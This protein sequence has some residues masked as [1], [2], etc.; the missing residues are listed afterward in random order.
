MPNEW[1]YSKK[2]KDKRWIKY[3][4]LVL[5]RDDHTCQDCGGKEEW[6]Y[7][8]HVHHIKY[9]SNKEPWEY[10]PSYVI[11]LCKRC[12]ENIHGLPNE[13]DPYVTKVS[14]KQIFK[15]MA[16]LSGQS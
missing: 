16:V 5:R 10:P 12:H 4:Y 3:R 14:I 8:L 1:D 9:I 13:R 2:L 15:K 11:T 6:G 7:Q